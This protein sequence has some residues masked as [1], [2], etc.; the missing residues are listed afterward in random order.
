[1]HD[2]HGYPNNNVELILGTRVTRLDPKAHTV[3]LDGAET[4]RYDKVAVGHWIPSAPAHPA[5]QPQPG[6]QVP[7]HDH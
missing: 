3:T 1:M 6:H 4:V 5:G 7:A 2:A